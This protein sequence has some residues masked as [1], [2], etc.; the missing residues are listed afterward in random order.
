MAVRVL[1]LF[2]IL[3]LS[4]KQLNL[5]LIFQYLV[6]FKKMKPHG[7]G[8]RLKAAAEIIMGGEWKQGIG[9]GALWHFECYKPNGDL[10]WELTESNIIVNVGLNDVLDQ[11]L[12]EGTG[13]AFFVGLKDTGVPVAADT[14]ASH[15]SWATI[16]PYSNGTNPQLLMGAAASQSIDNSAAKATFNINA[17]DEIFG[18]FV[19]DNNVVDAATGLLFGVVDF[20]ASRNVVNLDTLN[21][22]VT[23]TSASV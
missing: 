4:G 12:D 3:L 7:F 11:Y 22:T 1:L 17:T 13:P 8:A 18:A 23:V 2:T 6:E 15:A 10:R 14:M 5:V 9:I 16:S 20:A 19:T 21:V